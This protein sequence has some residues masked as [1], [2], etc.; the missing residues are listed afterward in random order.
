[1]FDIRQAPTPPAPKPVPPAQ[2]TPQSSAPPEPI[3]KDYASI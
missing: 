1:M 3:I 2:P